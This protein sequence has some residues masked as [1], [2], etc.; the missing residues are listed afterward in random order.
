ME[1]TGKRWCGAVTHRKAGKSLSV[2]GGST[3]GR[4]TDAMFLGQRAGWGKLVTGDRSIEMDRWMTV[5]R[6]ETVT[7]SGCWQ[8]SSFPQGTWHPHRPGSLS[9]GSPSQNMQ[10]SRPLELP[11]GDFRFWGGCSPCSK[12]VDGS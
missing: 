5:L 9:P 10:V 3:L 8:L 12:G 7:H 11:S 2:S 1:G 4:G 6:G